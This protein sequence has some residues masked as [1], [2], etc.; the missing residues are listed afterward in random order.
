MAQPDAPD[1]PR[2]S[3]RGIWRMGW[4]RVRR[5]VEWRSE[6]FQGIP[7]KITGKRPAGEAV[8]PLEVFRFNRRTRRLDAGPCGTRAP[9]RRRVRQV[10]G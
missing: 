6:I 2:R 5:G 7:A 3:P 9:G 10:V 8:F 1:A 4:R